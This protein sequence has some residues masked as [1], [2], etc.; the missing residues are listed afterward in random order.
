MKIAARKKDV[1]DKDALRAHIDMTGRKNT[2]TILHTQFLPIF[3]LRRG[4][5]QRVHC[6]FRQ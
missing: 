1:D 5:E 4:F 3:P 6:S 2:N